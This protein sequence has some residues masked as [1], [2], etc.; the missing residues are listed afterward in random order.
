QQLV[1]LGEYGQVLTRP[2]GPALV[3]PKVV[4]D[5][6][7]R[8]LLQYLHTPR[9]RNILL[10]AP[11][12]TGKTSLLHTLAHRIIAR[13]PVLPPAL[14]EIDLLELSPLL[15]RPGEVTGVTYL[16]PHEDVKHA[17]R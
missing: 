12:G 9:S 10:V 15:P 16:G 2:P 3:G 14:T 1:E 7:M 4:S 5:A 11:P 13:D 8:G 17:R 6:L